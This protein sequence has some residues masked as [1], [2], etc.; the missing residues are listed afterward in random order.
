[1]G[2]DEYTFYLTPAQ[3]QYLQVM[4]RGE[5]V[6]I[7]VKIGLVERKL[8][9]TAVVPNSPAAEKGIRPG[10]H[11]LRIDRQPTENPAVEVAWTRLLG[12]PGSV[13]EL[14]LLSAD[15]AMPHAVV[16]SR[17]PVLTPSVEWEPMPQEGVGYV[18]ILCFQDTTVQELKDAILQ[19]QAMQMKALVLDLRGNGGGVLL[20]AVQVAEL[21]LSEGT[22]V[23][24][25]SPVK[26]LRNV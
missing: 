23:Y 8:V 21:F 1:N 12:K 13:V 19:L 3:L 16:V 18:R 10:D 5:G 20:A 11:V 4:L 22:I 15:E 24:T 26:E 14:E 7:G 25:D 6:G 17:Q 2:L 9:V